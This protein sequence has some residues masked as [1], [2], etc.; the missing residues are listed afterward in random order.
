MLLDICF[1]FIID[2]VNLIM[3]D[4]LRERQLTW[5]KEAEELTVHNRDAENNMKIRIS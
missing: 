2:F 1:K 5:Q 4:F 3:Y